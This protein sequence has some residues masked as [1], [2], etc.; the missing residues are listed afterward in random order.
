[1][2]FTMK[3]QDHS[4]ED[5]IKRYFNP[6][7]IVKAP[8]GFTEKTIARIELESQKTNPLI[9][10][11]RSKKVPVI[12]VFVTFLLIAAAFLIPEEQNGGFGSAVLDYVRSLDLSFSFL[13]NLK[14]P[15]LP[16]WLLYSLMGIILVVIADIAFASFS[17]ERNS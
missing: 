8:G 10:F 3:N 12:S 1:M 7:V 5:L 9:D 15:E 16:G 2:L 11:W 13:K 6:R 14:L 4:E 17:E